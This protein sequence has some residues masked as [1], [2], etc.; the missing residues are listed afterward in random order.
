[1]SCFFKFSWRIIATDITAMIQAFFRDELDI[2]E[3]NKNCL[4][5]I[6]NFREANEPGDNAHLLNDNK[7]IKSFLSFYVKK[8]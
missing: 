1:M 3:I 6:P 7:F 2:Y 8:V 4:L 5:P